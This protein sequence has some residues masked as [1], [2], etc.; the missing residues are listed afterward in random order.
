M[1]AVVLL[2]RE[3]VAPVDVV[4]GRDT[5]PAKHGGGAVGGVRTGDACQ[6]EMGG[7]GIEE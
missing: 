2:L 7:R 3:V 5:R 1:L 4:R 6:R